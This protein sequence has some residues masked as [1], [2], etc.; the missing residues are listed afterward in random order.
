MEFDKNK[1]NEMTACTIRPGSMHYSILASHNPE[2]ST[3]S[4]Q[5]MHL[6]GNREVIMDLFYC[7]RANCDRKPSQIMYSFLITVVYENR[8]LLLLTEL[9][10]CSG[11]HEIEV[12]NC[13]EL[14]R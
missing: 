10:K 6:I 4:Y 11:S 9:H 1:K 12:C 13:M 7:Q 5:S 3:P 14:L 8:I 2:Q